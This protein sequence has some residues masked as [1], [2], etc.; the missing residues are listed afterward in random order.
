MLVFTLSTSIP[1]IVVAIYDRVRSR[2]DLFGASQG[3]LRRIASGAAAGNGPLLGLAADGQ[4]VVT[5]AEE[6]A[7]GTAVWVQRVLGSRL[8]RATRIAAPRQPAVALATGE[9]R[10]L[11]ANKFGT[12]AWVLPYRPP[13]KA[14][15]GL[16][17]DT[18]VTLDLAGDR[19]H[20]VCRTTAHGL[21][22][23]APWSGFGL[24]RLSGKIVRQEAW[25]AEDQGEAWPRTALYVSSRRELWAFGGE[26]TAVVWRRVGKELK[27]SPLSLAL[28]STGIQAI[29]VRP[30]LDALWDR[31]ARLS[32]GRVEGGVWRSVGLAAR[33][34]PANVD[35]R[36][37]LRALRDGSALIIASADTGTVW[38]IPVLRGPSLGAP[39]RLFHTGRRCAFYLSY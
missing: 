29:E 16:T 5:V 30:G 10:F 19:A 20:S 7:F 32:L 18:D 27:R 24:E 1:P 37:E 13:A 4:R 36:V 15:V 34:P 21:M 38:T 3:S 9:G 23:D 39:K 11:V 8:G 6:G 22:G 2:V 25:G 31:D 12:V 33:L 28:P 17:G 14:D 35:E 26:R